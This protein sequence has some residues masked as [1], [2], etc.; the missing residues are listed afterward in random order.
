MP[1]MDGYQA[2][3]SIRERED[4][5]SSIPIIALTANAMQGDAQ[6][7]TDAGMDDYMSKPFDT[8]KLESMINRLI[9]EHRNPQMG[10]A[11]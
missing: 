2:T 11:A 3:R 1:V 5:L 9:F 6:K 4:S 7:C 10:K 8:E